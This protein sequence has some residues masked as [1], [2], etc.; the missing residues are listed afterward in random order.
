L[1]ISR[2]PA[3]LGL[4]IWLILT[5]LFGLVGREFPGQSILLGA[6]AV[7]AGVLL[8][9]ASRPF[10][11]GSLGRLLLA[12][13]LIGMGLLSLVRGSGLEILVGLLALAAGVLLIWPVRR[14][15]GSAL[16]WLLLAVYLI[17]LG[18]TF[19]I[20]LSFSGLGVILAVLALAA[21]VLVLLGR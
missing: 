16:G 20:G 12:L 7:V 5:G 19:V 18:L 2:Q 9:L 1:R 10:G 17:L 15:F 13:S 11:R 8:L 4:A 21:G 6:L 14:S 3:T